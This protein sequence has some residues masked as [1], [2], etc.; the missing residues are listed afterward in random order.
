MI[1]CILI[2]YLTAFLFITRLLFIHHLKVMLC[3]LPN[4]THGR[5]HVSDVVQVFWSPFIHNSQKPPSREEVHPTLLAQLTGSLRSCHRLYHAFTRISF[6]K[7]WSS[8]RSVLVAHNLLVP[9]ILLQQWLTALLC[10]C[11][12][13]CCCCCWFI[14]LVLVCVHKWKCLPTGLT[15]YIVDNRCSVAPT[16]PLSVG[17]RD[18]TGFNCI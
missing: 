14:L 1:S 8:I 9:L 12:F 3:H 13:C 11:V 7:T 2:L 10:E 5:S 15:C 16:S 6:G 4:R 17:L 18:L